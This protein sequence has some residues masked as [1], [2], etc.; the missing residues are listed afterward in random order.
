[1]QNPDHQMAHYAPLAKAQQFVN[2]HFKSLL[3]KHD[4][5]KL[6]DTLKSLRVKKSSGTLHLLDIDRLLF[7]LLSVRR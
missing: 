3:A 5:S 1:M 6:L 4:Y 7:L 2:N